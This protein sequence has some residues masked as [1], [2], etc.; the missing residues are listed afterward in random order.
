[1]AEEISMKNT[2]KEMLEIINNLQQQIKEKE[3]T[4]LDP[5]K[6]KKETLKTNLTPRYITLKFP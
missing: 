6:I 2:K 5:E 1:M 3:K 4:K